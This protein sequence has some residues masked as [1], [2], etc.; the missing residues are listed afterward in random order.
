[1]IR[2]NAGFAGSWYPSDAGQCQREIRQFLKEGEPP[3]RGDFVCG[4]VPHAGWFFSGA[5]ACRVMAAMAE[6]TSP[7]LV[8]IFGMHMHPNELPRILSRG[9]WETPLGNLDIH[10]GFVRE[11]VKRVGVQLDTPDTFPGDNT[12]EV[13]LPMV[14]YFFPTA[15]MVPVG[16]PPSPVAEQ[17]GVESVDVARYLGIDM[18]VV[19]STDLTHYG[20]NFGFAPAGT[21][22]KAREWMEKENDAAAMDAMQAMDVDTILSQGRQRQN[23]CCAGAVAATVASARALGANKSTVLGYSNSFDKNPGSSMVGYTG[24]LF[25]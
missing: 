18:V 22:V 8:L 16:V 5:L 17:I 19:G 11:L 20:E 9:G 3:L 12:I 24:V 25:G 4:I 7:D 2:K 21:G 14:K 13:Q 15:C 23:M 10:D 1:M 6:K